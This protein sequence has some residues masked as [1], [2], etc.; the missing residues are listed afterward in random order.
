MLLP[1]FKYRMHQS[2][3]Q[4]LI[5][6]P[7]SVSKTCQLM[8]PMSVPKQEDYVELNISSEMVNTHILVFRK[9]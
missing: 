4:A 1:Q 5:H 8:P 7:A 6:I 9:K 2:H 3:L